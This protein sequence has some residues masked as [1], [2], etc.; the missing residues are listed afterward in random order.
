MTPRSN[1]RPLR[2][3]APST[4]GFSSQNTSRA[5][6][7]RLDELENILWVSAR[8]I[9]E[10]LCSLREERVANGALAGAWGD[11]HTDAGMDILRRNGIM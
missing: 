3:R 11:D 8:T 1:F 10:D 2:Y 4:A 5:R 9:N 6:G 7:A